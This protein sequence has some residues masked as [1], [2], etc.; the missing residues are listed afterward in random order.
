MT[1][2]GCDA[3]I[4]LEDDCNSRYWFLL[5]YS[6]GSPVDFGSRGANDN[7]FVVVYYFG[8]KALPSTRHLSC[9]F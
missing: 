2:T 5:M 4:L 7:S 3:V 1:D 9:Y 8:F 6:H